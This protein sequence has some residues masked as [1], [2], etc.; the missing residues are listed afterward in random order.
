M[1]LIFDTF[2]DKVVGYNNA[3]NSASEMM[4]SNVGVFK[5]SAMESDFI[6]QLEFI[7]LLLIN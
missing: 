7:L 2:K 5:M 1:E 6:T 3:T 4:Q